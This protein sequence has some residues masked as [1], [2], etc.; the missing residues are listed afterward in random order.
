MNSCNVVFFGSTSDSVLVL[1]SLSGLRPPAGPLRQIEA[2]EAGMTDYELR[3]S[4]VVTQ[5]PKPVGRSQTLTPTPV[6]LWAQA[7]TIPVLSF[8][9]NPEKSW[10][11]E[12]EQTVIDA[13]EPFKADLLVSASYGQKIPA[14]TITD[15]HNGAL[16]VHPS[17]L[18]RWRGADPVPWA[19]L[20]GDHQIGVSVV[21]LSENF[22]EGKILGLKKIP[23]SAHDRSDALRTQLFSLGATLLTRILPDYIR[24]KIKGEP[25]DGKKAIYARK[26]TRED[27]FMTWEFLKQL[28]EGVQK[29][30]GTVPRVYAKLEIDDF[31]QAVLRAERALNPWPGIWTMVK[32]ADGGEKRLKIIDLSLNGNVLALN[33]VQLEGKKPVS[34]AQFQTAYL[35]R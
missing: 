13:V 9:S 16:N 18:P 32:M 29:P 28:M 26:F 1:E 24:G 2:S 3:I 23:M 11:Y 5:P 10:E 31:I 33:T 8:P 25:Q 19:I 34:Y 15:A 4:C 14:K 21:T 30:S 6:A 7:H 17:I 35:R 20:A 27:G 22:D 12:S